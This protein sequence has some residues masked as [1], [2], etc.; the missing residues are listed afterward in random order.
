MG[1]GEGGFCDEVY[2]RAFKT[3]ALTVLREVLTLALPVLPTLLSTL[4]YFKKKIAP[5]DS[6]IVICAI[7]AVVML[8]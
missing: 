4:F 6:V 8:F 2:A 5:R 3:F 1:A 7:L